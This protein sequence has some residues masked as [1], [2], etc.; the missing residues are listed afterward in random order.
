MYFIFFKQKAAYEIRPRD[1]SSDV[2]S[3]DLDDLAVRSRLPRMF[4]LELFSQSDV[5]VN[6]AVHAQHGARVAVDER[7]RAVLDVDYREPLVG[8]ECV[9]AG[10]DAAPIGTAMAHARRHFQRLVAQHW[11]RLAYFEY[12]D[13]TAHGRNSDCGGWRKFYNREFTG[14]STGVFCY[15]SAIPVPRDG[16]G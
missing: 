15:R 11:R 8:D 6:L 1:W 12:A 13:D 9:L 10:V 16:P 7:L 3:S 14:G 4:P 2:C 5:V